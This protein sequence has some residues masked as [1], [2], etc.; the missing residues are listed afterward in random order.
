MKKDKSFKKRQLPLAYISRSRAWAYFCD[1][2]ILMRQVQVQRLQEN[3][4]KDA[5]TC[6]LKL[7]KDI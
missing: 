5:L 4:D 2:N 6:L 3:L 1:R 7:S